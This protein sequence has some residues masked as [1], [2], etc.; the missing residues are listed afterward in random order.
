MFNNGTS[1]LTS[2]NN[3]YLSIKRSI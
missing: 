2:I 1:R 3:I